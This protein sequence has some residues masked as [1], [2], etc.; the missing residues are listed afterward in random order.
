MLLDGRWSTIGH[1]LFI[2]LVPRWGPISHIENTT[3]LPHIVEVATWPCLNG[4]T[5]LKPPVEFSP[6]PDHCH[7]SL[8]EV[9]EDSLGG[10][11]PVWIGYLSIVTRS[12]SQFMWSYYMLLP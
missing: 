8:R 3:S 9:R 10:A 2:L 7:V 11:V 4:S 12:T 1:S 5:L 6:L